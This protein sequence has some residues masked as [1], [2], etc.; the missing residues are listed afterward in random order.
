MVIVADSRGF[1]DGPACAF[2][3][4]IETDI[5]IVLVS[6]VEGF[7]FNEALNS[8][9][10]KKWIYCEFIEYGW[11]WEQKSSIK[12]G[13]NR[14]DFDFLNVGEWDKLEDFIVNNPPALS[15]V[16]ELVKE[17]A[18]ETVLPIEYPNLTNPYPIQTKEE[19]DARRIIAFNFWGRSH[20]ARVQLHGDL[21]KGASRYDYS[22]CDNMYFFSEFMNQEQG[23]KLVSLWTPHYARVDLSNMLAIASMSKFTFSLPGAGIKCFRSTGEA[24]VASIPVMVEDKLAWTYPFIHNE[25]SIKYFRF[26]DELE[27]IFEAL[28]NPNLYDIYRESLNTTDKYRVNNYIN[29]YI[30]PNINKV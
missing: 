4:R 24:G 28:Q 10:G 22:L 21:W 8:L 18:S 2:L 16:R 29:N 26:G 15:F 23:R 19:F 1:S 30:L 17:D 7:V 3:Q 14:N 20:E 25:N 6:R 9:I 11:L 13:V 5:P 27:T 12:W